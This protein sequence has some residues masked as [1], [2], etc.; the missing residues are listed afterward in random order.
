MLARRCIEGAVAAPSVVQLDV[1]AYGRARDLDA[2]AVRALAHAAET[3]GRRRRPRWTSS[4]LVASTRSARRAGIAAGAAA[5]IYPRAVATKLGAALRLV[6]LPVAAALLVLGAVGSARGADAGAADAAPEVRADVDAGAAPVNAMRAELRALRAFRDGQP[7]PVSSVELFRVDLRDDAAVIV[8]LA[9]IARALELARAEAGADAGAAPDAEAGV[10]TD[11]GPLEDESLLEAEAT[12]A[13]ARALTIR[14][15]EVRAEILGAP[16]ERRLA[17]LE[18]ERAAVAAAASAQ[19]R[20]STEEEARAAE[21]ARLK[22]IQAAQAARSTTERRLAEVRASVEKARGEQARARLALADRRRAEARRAAEREDRLARW[23]KERAALAP[24]SPEAD[25]LFDQVVAQLVELRGA[26]TE[27]LVELEGGFSVTRA[28]R[29]PLP[30][31]D[32]AELARERQRLED[33]RGA[34]ARAA[35]ELEAEQLE[36]AWGALR[37][38]MKVEHA[39]NDLR[40]ELFGL[41]SDD[42]RS[43]LLGIGDEGRAQILREL[44][45]IR[46]EVRWLRASGD[47]LVREEWAELKRPSAIGRLSI[48]LLAALAVVWATFTVRRR[49]APWLSELRAFAARV[50]KRKALVRPV[51]AFADVLDAVGRELVLVLG[52]VA[53][54]RVARLEVMHGPWAVPYTL[55]FWYWVYRFT[56]V[57]TH[58][59]LEWVAERGTMGLRAPTRVKI[60]RSVRLVGR[61][62]FA[63]AFILAGAAA[64]LGRGYLYVQVARVGWLGG[65]AI[66]AVLVRWWRDDIARTYLRMR[67]KGALSSAVSRTRTRWVGFFVTIVAFSVL[68]GGAVGRAG[69]RF[70][71]GFEQSRKALAFMFRRR[72]EKQAEQGEEGEVELLDPAVLAF[73][74]E[75]PV[76][77]ED[78]RI[79]RAPGLDDFEERAARFRAGDRVGA[80]LVVGRT[81]FGKSTWLLAAE[82]RLGDLPVTRLDLAERA[83]DP[84]AVL[85]AIARACGAHG[86]GLEAIVSHLREHPRRAIFVDDAQ[87]WFLRGVGRLGGWRAFS[88]LVER[89]SD[90]VLWV[91]A[92]AHYPWE[93]LSWT[94]KDDVVF[95]AVVHLEPWSEAE[96]GDLLG[97]RN[98]ASALEVVYDDLLVERVEGVD[99]RAQV[100]TTARDYNRLVWDYAEGSPRVALHVWA[101]SL[102]PDGPG[103]ARVR[104]FH[105]PESQW[106]EA[107]RESVRFVLAAIVWHE[108]LS[109]GEACEVLRIPRVV[110]EDAFQQLLDRGV[111]ERQGNAVRVAPLWW[112]LVVRYLRRK[113]LIET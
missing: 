8:R 83:T 59:G 23:Q 109:V 35:A 31:T 107:R 22:A 37:S 87:L 13:L 44:A 99:A 110:C 103:R 70:V 45:R 81:G 84:R 58:R 48:Q 86:D 92:F 15:L 80:T 61:F 64:V 5:V 65:T 72:L 90:C 75:Q 104:L 97:K 96:I 71:L 38:T 42:K 102:V 17:L 52:I 36:L 63:I 79:D 4:R 74:T 6:L 12:P 85:G 53:L 49:L 19:E 21:E 29:D 106:L 50:L 33:D 93:F 3:R 100:L 98:A 76:D 34:L 56:L 68:L 18:A 69:R 32:D 47:R 43:S 11:A 105:S 1:R 55:L 113:H 89:T 60:L 101:R 20:R 57:S 26:A 78:L 95:R 51:T 25:A 7:A 27:V 28:D 2:V 62:A 14:L 112:P 41:V 39:L 30:G 108:R 88:E 94:L 66:L 111:A 9:E 91:V 73:F 16:R 77:D 10:V 82:R 54:P 40:I 46:L 67:P 24:G